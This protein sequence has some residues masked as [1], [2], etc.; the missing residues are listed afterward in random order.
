MATTENSTAVRMKAGIRTSE[1]WISLATTAWALVGP[2]LPPVAQAVIG[3]GVPAAY[4]IGRALVKAAAI[5][6]AA[7]P[8]RPPAPASSSSSTGDP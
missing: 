7:A 6:A 3:V 8:P 2:G 1:F 5:K 4:T